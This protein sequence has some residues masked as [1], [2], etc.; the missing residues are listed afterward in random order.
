MKNFKQFISENHDYLIEAKTEGAKMEEIIVAAWNNSPIPKSS[1]I[2]KDAGKKIVNFLKSQG[3]TGSK[4]YKLKT[5]GV[6]VTDE[7][8]SF[9]FPDN[10]TGA[11]KTPKTDIVIGNQS[12]SIKTG[13]AQLMSGGKKEAKATF[14]A[15][16]KRT[17]SIQ[18]DK[19]AKE[20]YFKLDKLSE[21]SLTKGGTVEQSLK[22]NNDIF[23]NKANQ[24][25]HEIKEMLE[26][27]F[28]K[29][30]EFKQNFIY[31]A[32]SG[33]VKFGDPPPKAVWLLS[34]DMNGENNKFVKI[35]NKNLIRKISNS[36]VVDCRFKSMSQ[37]I[38]KE[39]TGKYHYYG[40]LGLVTKKL[41]EEFEQ[42]NEQLLTE[43]IITGIYEKFK[44]Y[45]KKLLHDVLEWLKGGIKRITEF[46]EIEPDISFNNNIN[47]SEL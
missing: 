7:W 23:L 44:N 46:F 30:E 24:L 45:V 42:Y 19:L 29:N 39:K 36:T 3:V 15:A 11:T 21:L 38:K 41:K 26:N 20:I 28:N 31:E 40:V 27:I 5:K 33:D 25:N 4:A 37:K 1:K 9:W 16:V 6:E 22:K 10:V 18:S 17:T 2:H 43:N 32:M 34:T 14:Y 35:N 8:A 12:I 13:N 47:F